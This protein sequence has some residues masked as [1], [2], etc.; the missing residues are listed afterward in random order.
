MSFVRGEKQPRPF[1][2]GGSHFLFLGISS[3]KVYQGQQL[4][5]ILMIS[6]TSNNLLISLKARG[7]SDHFRKP[8]AASRIL[9]RGRTV[10]IKE[11]AHLRCRWQARFA[12]QHH[13]MM[14]FWFSEASFDGSFQK[15]WL[16][17]GSGQKEETTPRRN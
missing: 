16:S 12:G 3:F 5:L 14:S 10:S 1:R 8:C 11:R 7:G 15:D 4:L 9:E 6:R 17:A 13:G 2:S